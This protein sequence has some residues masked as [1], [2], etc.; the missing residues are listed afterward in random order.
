MA[1]LQPLWTAP[2]LTDD[3]EIAEFLA[4]RGARFERWPLPDEVV[5]IAAKDFVDAQ[6]AQRL[7][8]AFATQLADK[9]EGERYR[10]ADVVAIRPHLPGID[11][12]LARFDRVH[13]HDDDEVRAIVGGRGV[14]GFADPDG[15]Q[16]L[17]TVEPGDYIAVP[18]G[19]WHW[20][21]CLE[22]RNITALRLF[23]DTAGWEA[24]YRDEG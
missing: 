8:D 16:F 20:F 2:A 22:D 5:A 24:K 3:S 18:A 23:T 13:R 11:G 4:A 17:L 9:A 6:D 7:L 21:Y 1:L 10:A 12:A 15:R 19:V 14:F